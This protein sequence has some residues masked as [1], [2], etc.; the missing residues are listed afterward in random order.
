MVF[1]RNRDTLAQDTVLSP[2]IEKSA[3]LARI[4]ATIAIH[5]GIFATN[6]TVQE[7]T[8]EFLEIS[9]TVAKELLEH[10]YRSLSASIQ[11]FRSSLSK[12]SP[13]IKNGDELIETLS[14]LMDMKVNQEYLKPGKIVDPTKHF[15]RTTEIMKTT[16]MTGETLVSVLRIKRAAESLRKFLKSDG[17][18]MTAKEKKKIL[19]ELG[20]SVILMDSQLGDMINY[21]TIMKDYLNLE[22]LMDDL[23]NVVS[24]TKIAKKY[25]NTIEKLDS[26]RND[27]IAASKG[28]DKV[29]EAIEEVSKFF[30]TIKNL[31]STSIVLNSTVPRYKEKVLTHGLLSQKDLLMFINDFENPWFQKNVLSNLDPAKLKSGLENLKPFVDTLE[32]LISIKQR[33]FVNSEEKRTTLDLVKKIGDV[34]KLGSKVLS[35]SNINSTFDEVSKCI[36]PLRPIQNPP[37][38]EKLQIIADFSTNIVKN[39]KTFSNLM[40]DLIN[41]SLENTKTQAFELFLTIRTVFTKNDSRVNELWNATCEFEKNKKLADKYEFIASKLSSAPDNLFMD[42]YVDYDVMKRISTIFEGAN[43]DTVLNCIERQSVENLVEMLEFI[44]KSHVLK[45]QET[46]FKTA[47]NFIASISAIQSKYKEIKILVKICR[48]T[49]ESYAMMYSGDLQKL[50]NTSITIG[51]GVSSLRA[52]DNILKGEE[53]I[54]SVANAKLPN[55]DTSFDDSYQKKLATILNMVK[56]ITK[57]VESKSQESMKNLENVFAT[58]SNNTISKLNIPTKFLQK[59]GLEQLDSGNLSNNSNPENQ[60]IGQDFEIVSNLDMNFAKHSMA[61]GSM[62]GSFELT[63]ESLAEFLKNRTDI[64]KPVKGHFI[65]FSDISVKDIVGIILILAVAVWMIATS[66]FYDRE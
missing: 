4:S 37:D 15:S 51:K 17:Q 59:I 61:F 30:E 21:K 26:F 44:I 49:T 1:I 7:V 20:T 12:I 57:T 45:E 48:L 50:Q 65:F 10:D 56:N 33:I 24:A 39:I 66:A 38:P 22:S 35:L 47:S 32:T 36:E 63:K 58:L 2:F 55:L 42:G 16:G 31:T 29:E 25:S 5:N 9:P 62:K 3:S 6:S 52:L 64:V 18:A 14:F 46:E 8:A 53:S 23:Q 28:M 13:D 19:S 34:S 40:D 54:L 27:L 11:K 43:V 41:N 60:T